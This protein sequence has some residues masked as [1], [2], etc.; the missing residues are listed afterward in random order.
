MSPAFENN[1][2]DNAPEQ[3]R[4]RAF[5]EVGPDAAALLEAMIQ[6]I[7]SLSSRVLVLELKLRDLE[8]RK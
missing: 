7:N 3:I 8:A 2:A 5:E 1:S 6:E 4:A